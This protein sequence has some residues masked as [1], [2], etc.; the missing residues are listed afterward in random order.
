MGRPGEGG[1]SGGF[2]FGGHSSDRDS[3]GHRIGG[4]RPGFDS[5]FERGFDRNFNRRCSRNYY[6]G[7]HQRSGTG[8]LLFLMWLIERLINFFST[9]SQREKRGGGIEKTTN[10]SN[11][12][13]K[14]HIKLWT[15]ISIVLLICLIALVFGFFISSNKNTREKLDVLSS[16]NTNCVIDEEGWFDSPT[17]VGKDLKAFYNKTGVQPYIVV[18]SYNPDLSTDSVKQEYAQ[19]WYSKNID[20]EATFLYM[21]FGESSSNSVGYMAYVSGKQASNVMDSEVVEKFWSTLDKE[22]YS[23]K[24]SDK[25]FVDTFTQTANYAMKGYSPAPMLVFLVLTGIS[26]TMVF[27]SVRNQREKEKAEETER[28]LNSDLE[29][30][31]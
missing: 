2:D 1:D 27:I 6:G 31:L 9:R 4:E 5:D 24:S 18:N 13:Y 19:E 14:N 26:F 23:D 29:D 12:G 10:S 28:I 8:D 25:L 21:Y 15:G 11:K 16:Y 7:F 17:K 20:N 3:G 22:W 30:L